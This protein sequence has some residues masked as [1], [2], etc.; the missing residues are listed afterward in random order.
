MYGAITGLYQVEKM[1]ICI[2]ATSLLQ[3]SCYD[4]IGSK[5]TS[6]GISS[7]N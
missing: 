5:D 3:H 4:D 7:C 6:R 1:H 2:N